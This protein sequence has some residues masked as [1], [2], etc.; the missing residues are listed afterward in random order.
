MGRQDS[1]VTL[2]K[3]KDSAVIS[4]KCEVANSPVSRMVGLIGK[5][6]LE[7]GSGLLLPRCK[8]I[9]MW[10]MSV[11]IDVVFLREETTGGGSST[12]VVSSLHEG[13]R[14]WRLLPLNDFKADAVVELPVN[15]IRKHG[16]TRGDGLCIA[17]R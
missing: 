9:H 7:D 15:T 8:S 10:F 1:I 5:T 11:P 14:P 4:E 17:S 3:L 12:W 6:H 16:L 2:K 13:V